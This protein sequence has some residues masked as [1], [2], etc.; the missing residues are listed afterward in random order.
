MPVCTTCF[1]NVD[2]LANK[3]RCRKCYNDYMREYM[4]NRYYQKRKQA[5][6]LL[7]SVCVDCGSTTELEVDHVDPSKKLVEIGK[8]WSYSKDR[9]LSEITKCAL[10]C[11]PCHQ[12]KTST[13]LSVEHG[14]GLTG[15]K[16][17]NCGK[18]RPLK[19]AYKR[20]RRHLT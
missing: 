5:I 14:G 7:G 20:N 9:F 2:S 15:K 13:F 19:L 12:I 16:N 10:R 4:L 1:S 11:K 6:E 8:I 17:C 3:N 18:C